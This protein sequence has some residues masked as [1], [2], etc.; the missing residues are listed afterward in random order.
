MVLSEFSGAEILLPLIDV[1]AVVMC[2]EIA[3]PE[4]NCADSHS[5]G[6]NSQY[7]VSSP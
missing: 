4:I 7:I 6:Q 1:T 5:N 2:V 3:N